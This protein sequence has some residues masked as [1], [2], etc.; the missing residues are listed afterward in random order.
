MRGGRLMQYSKP[1][2]PGATRQS[3][4]YI[5]RGRRLRAARGRRRLSGRGSGVDN[6]A[7]RAWA[8]SEGLQDSERGRISAD[9]ILYCLARVV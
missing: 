9:V 1:S 2:R 7:V 8:K 4:P 6:A 3:A 5:E